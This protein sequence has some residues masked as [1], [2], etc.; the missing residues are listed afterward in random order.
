VDGKPPV[1]AKRREKAV[2]EVTQQEKIDSGLVR[3][4]SKTSD[5]MIIEDIEKGLSIEKIAKIYNRDVDD[6]KK[7]IGKIKGKIKSRR[8]KGQDDNFKELYAAIFKKAA[9]DDI[10]KAKVMVYDALR[11]NGINR[12]EVDEFVNA[13]VEAVVRKL[14]LKE[15]LRYPKRR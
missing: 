9:R 8:F 7:H 2:N 5:R 12:K 10:A 14:V 6:L 1:Y 3:P 4:Y 11:K 13:E 15:A